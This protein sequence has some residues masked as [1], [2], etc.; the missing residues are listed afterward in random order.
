[1]AKS[2]RFD[3]FK[4]YLMQFNEE[5]DRME[6][7]LCDLSNALI[8]AQGMKTSNR[9]FGIGN[10][11]ARLQEI[12][13]NN[14]KWEM[15]FLRIRKDNFP[16]RAHDNGSID[17]FT[18]LS[19]EEGFGEEVSAI[20]DPSN[21]VIMVRRNIHSL[22]P[23]VISN[24]F[25][26]LLNTIGL[27]VLFKPMIH[28]GSLALLQKDH[29]IRSAEVAVADVKSASPRTKRALGSIVESTEDM[30]ETVNIV[31]KIGL[32]QKG[33]RKSSKLPIYEEI[34]TFAQDDNI[35]RAIVKVKA[36]EDAKVET[37]DLIKNRLVDY[38]Q[39]SED[40]IDKK[41]RTIR[42]TTVI[43]RMHQAYRK[44]LNDINN[45]YK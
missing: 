38:E 41:S 1:M 10:D 22:S 14:N 28:P 24:Y 11:L 15:H 3:Y 2:V 29:L 7:G 31:F 35:K 8:K 42:H 37:I 18:D 45:I 32:E 44:R 36:D 16:I 21:F 17:F 12:S 27:T 23:Q 33:S 19:E 30:N 43:S 40:D 39:F 13:F 34:A 26:N 20:F 9:V 4:V 25:T 6:E 5:T